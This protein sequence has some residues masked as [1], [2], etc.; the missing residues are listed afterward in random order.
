MENDVIIDVSGISMMFNLSNE[1]IDNIKEY[2][3]KFLK[4]ELMFNE[5]WALKDVSFS[6]KKGE[7]VGLVGLNGSGKSTMLKVIAGVMKPTKGKVLVNG[8]IAPLIE[9]GAGFDTDLS[10]RENIYLNGAMLGFS[11]K[12]MNEKFNEIMDF[13]EL[14]EFV[15]VAIKN[16]SSGM[17][18]RLGFSIATAS[19][20]D[21]LIVDEI[22][23]VGDY[24]FQQ[25]CEERIN[26]M[27]EDGTTIVM[28]SHSIDQVKRI[29]KKAV[30]LESGKV[31]M[32][33]DADYVCQEYQQ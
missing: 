5:F 1:K 23:A 3:I 24:K 19:R 32:Y 25:K 8:T 21:I 27:I 12:Q 15:D 18:A 2:V 30:W 31:R 11:K 14:W 17:L 9:L 10:A 22:L 29:C 20:P 13:A 33:G 26:K 4:R 16:F 7:S 28:V 6:I